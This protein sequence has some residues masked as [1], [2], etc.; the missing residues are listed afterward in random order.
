MD[1]GQKINILLADDRPENLLS[2]EAVLDDPAYELARACSG[3]EALKLVLD[4]DFA[5]ILL[6][7][8]MPGMDGFE[9]AVH[10]RKL[11]RCK[12]TPIIFVTAYSKDEQDI[13]RGYNLGAVDYVFKPIAPEILRAKVKVFA[14][15]FDKT[16]QLARQTEQL[17]TERDQLNQEL[18]YFEMISGHRASQ[19]TSQI[20]GGK[21]LRQE[22]PSEFE[23][24]VQE[25][26]KNLVLAVERQKFKMEQ[27]TSESVRSLAERLGFLRAG[28]RDVVEIHTQ[29]MKNLNQNAPSPKI[30]AFIQ[31]GRMLLI[32]L[33]GLLVAYY[34]TRSVNHILPRT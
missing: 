10:I 22:I 17:K 16:R 13:R 25:Y 6:D 8:K 29:A 14:E 18:Q 23:S 30:K 31:E 19:I 21:A 24:M 33:L 11:E 2:L 28:P 5:V 15:L 12:N 3:E 4:Q 20:F 7:A 9:T 27:D 1:D 32:E 26:A 34:R